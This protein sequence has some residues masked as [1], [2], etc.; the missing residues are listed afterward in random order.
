MVIARTH[1]AKPTNPPAGGEHR[2]PRTT[3]QGRSRLD[4]EPRLVPAPADIDPRARVSYV[5]PPSGPKSHTSL[6]QAPSR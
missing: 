3:D 4:R 6:P 5:P 1:V 2:T